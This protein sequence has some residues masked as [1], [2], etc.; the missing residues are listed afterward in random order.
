MTEESVDQAKECDAFFDTFHVEPQIH[1]SNSFTTG[2]LDPL[3]FAYLPQLGV[4]NGTIHLLLHTYTHLDK[5]MCTLRIMFFEFSSELNTIWSALHG[6]KGKNMQVNILTQ[7]LC[8][9]Q[10]CVHFSSHV[11]ISDSE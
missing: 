8:R 7:V 2:S 5:P 9:E 11:F 6:E 3:Q 1:S 4:D 10:F